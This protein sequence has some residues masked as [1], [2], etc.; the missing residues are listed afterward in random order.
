MCFLNCHF[1]FN[2]KF[3]YF[4]FKFLLLLLKEDYLDLIKNYFNN[5][6][7]SSSNLSFRKNSFV[8]IVNYM[9]IIFL[10]NNILKV[11]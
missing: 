4:K 8:Q 1:N 6:S 10:N 5:S 9:S 7:L 11:S 3:I 2:F